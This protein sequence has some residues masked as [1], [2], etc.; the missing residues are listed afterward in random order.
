MEQNIAVP[1]N[2]L[3]FQNVIFPFEDEKTKTF[4]LLQKKKTQILPYFT[5][6]KKILNFKTKYSPTGGLQL[7]WLNA[8][9]LLDDPWVYLEKV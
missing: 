4:L 5:V 1:R 2:I 9:V 7:N 6:G 8:L 3:W